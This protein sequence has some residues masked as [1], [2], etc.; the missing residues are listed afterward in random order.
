MVI[1]KITS[2]F[3]GVIEHI[4]IEPGA[5]VYEWENLLFIKT[6]EGIEEVKIGVS[7]KV[8]KLHVKKGDVVKPDM[9]LAELEDDLII[10]GAD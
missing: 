4:L 1:E 9:M 6:T 8:A 5:Y 3:Y 2:P 7:G 10:S